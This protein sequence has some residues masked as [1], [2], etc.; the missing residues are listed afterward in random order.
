MHTKF[1]VIVVGA[2]AVG[3]AAAYHAAR[4][5]HRV[6]LLEQF[7]IDHPFGSSYGAS[8]IIRYAYD[9]PAY[10]ELAKSTFPGWQAL[11]AEAGEQLY[12]RTG[13]I[14]FGAA[15]EPSLA[16]TA[17]SLEAGGVAFEVLQPDEARRRFAQFRFGDGQQVIYQADAGVLAASKCVRAQVRLAEQHGAVIQP[18]TPVTGIDIG[19]DSVTITT[20]AGAFSAAR[21]ILV[22][23]AWGRAVFRMV[24]LALPLTPVR[25]QEGY[26][27]AEPADDFEADRFPVFISHTPERSGFMT[28]GLPSMDGSGLKVGMHGGLPVADATTMDRSP[29]MDAVADTREFMR[30]HLPAGADAPLRLARPCLYT[31]TPDEHFVIDRHPQHPHVVISASCSGHAFKFSHLIGEILCDLAFTGATWHD[32][33]M[34]RLNRFAA[35]V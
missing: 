25:A 35:H 2:G 13:G 33:G 5:G 26:F 17:R 31:M 19:G 29:D 21:L 3:S 28:Y 20:P 7:E 16:E 23:G 32:I 24:G 9:H 8:R 10:V 27:A 30:R 22:P 18:S 34:F 1:D 15:D 11:E 6:L 12:T 4:A 14:D